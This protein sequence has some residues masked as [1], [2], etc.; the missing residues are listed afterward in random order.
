MRGVGAQLSLVQGL[1]GGSSRDPGGMKRASGLG[2]GACSGAEFW[3]GKLDELETA[4]EGRDGSE[5]G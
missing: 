2:S 5:S 4:V 3:P 1:D